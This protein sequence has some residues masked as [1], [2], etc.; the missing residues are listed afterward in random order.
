MA[1]DSP[2]APHGSHVEV[3][4]ITTSGSYPSNGTERVA[5]NQPV[6]IELAKAV[7]ELHIVDTTAWIARVNGT[8]INPEKSYTQDGLTGT[9]KIDYGPREGGGGD[10]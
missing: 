4:I 7:R 10:E 5:A 8:E 2:E 6:R 3:V 1:E 9:V